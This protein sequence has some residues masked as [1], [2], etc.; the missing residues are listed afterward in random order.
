MYK[1]NLEIRE[2]KSTD[3]WKVISN[4]IYH[5]QTKNKQWTYGATE[6]KLKTVIIL[7][8]GWKY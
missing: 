2:Y 8:H 5:D 6:L 1:W 3:Q 4:K 7:L